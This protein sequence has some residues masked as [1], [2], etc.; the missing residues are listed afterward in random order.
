MYKLNSN[1]SLSAIL[2]TENYRIMKS[3]ISD[4]EYSIENW[5]EGD[6]WSIDE[7]RRFKHELE[8]QQR[9]YKGVA[10]EH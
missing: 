5:R 6:Y 8:S 9:N 3:T 1:F 2:E 4:I 7:L 10:G